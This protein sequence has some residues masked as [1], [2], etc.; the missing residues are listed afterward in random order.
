MCTVL[1][2]TQAIAWSDSSLKLVNYVLYVECSSM[3]D[4]TRNIWHHFKPETSHMKGVYLANSAMWVRNMVY[5]TVT[6]QQTR[7][8]WSLVLSLN[9]QIVLRQRVTKW[10]QTMLLSSCC[11]IWQCGGPLTR[12]LCCSKNSSQPAWKHPPGRLRATWLRTGEGP[13][14]VEP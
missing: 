3:S 12:N 9:P 4:L 5:H 2:Y 11:P 14:C 10:R 13:C 7:H 8:L 1:C 6:L